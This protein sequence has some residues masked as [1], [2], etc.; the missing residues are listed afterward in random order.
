MAAPS[1]T[2]AGKPGLG[3]QPWFAFEDFEL[4]PYSTL[5]VN[6]ANGNLLVKAND[7]QIAVPGYGLRQDR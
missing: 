2:V 5:H 1:G 7:S 4:S 6:I 3:E